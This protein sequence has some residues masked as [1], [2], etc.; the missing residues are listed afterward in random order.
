MATSSRI[1]GFYQL[2]I[3]ERRAA[4]ETHLELAPGTL[5]HCLSRQGLD[6]S[7]ADKIAENVLG[8]YALPFCVQLNVELNGRDRVVPMVV[9][10]PSVVAAASNAA[11]IVRNA[12]GFQAT[13][14]EALMIAQ[15]QLDCVQAPEVARKAIR[16]QWTHLKASADAAVPGLLKRGGGIRKMEVRD[17]GEGLMVIHLLIDCCDAMG[18]NLVNTVAESLGPQLAQLSEG[19]LGLRI[20]S[21]LSDRRRVQVTCRAHACDLQTRD[22]NGQVALRGVDVI[23][24]IVRA[25]RFAERDPYRAATHNKGLMNGL[26]SVLLATGND[27]RAVEAGAHAYAAR[28]GKYGPLAIWHREEDQLVGKLEVPLAVGTV[29]GT[30]RVHPTAKLALRLAEISSANDLAML[31]AS[32]GL[33]SNLAALRAL[34]TEGIQRGHMSLHARAI[35]TAAGANTLEVDGIA[36]QMA[37]TGIVTSAEAERLLLLKRK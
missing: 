31:A 22:R 35:A 23:D 28:S 33:A 37:T 4:L 36:H 14:P 12:G 2:S 19:R 17:L 27:Y 32:A 6:S 7:A 8:I 3:S 26:D 21:N 16:A 11:R 1:P 5:E 9:E 15:V 13:V 29:G 25:S 20:L 10:E 34:S 24:A 30:L 18:A